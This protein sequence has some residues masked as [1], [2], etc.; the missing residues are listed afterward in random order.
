M[1]W[2]CGLILVVFGFIFVEL[3]TVGVSF[4][5]EYLLDWKNRRKENQHE[6]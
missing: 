4:L 6:V 5:I 2:L 1:G 3:F